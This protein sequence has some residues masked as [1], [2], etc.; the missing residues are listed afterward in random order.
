MPHFFIKKEQIINNFIE[1]QECDDFFHLTKSLRIKLGGCVKFIDEDKNVY[2][3]QIED[4]TKKSLKAKIISKKNSNRLLKTDLCLIQGVLALDSQ[5]LLIANATQA[6]IKEL[7]PIICDNSTVSIKNAKDK[8]D[9]WQKIAY[10]NFKQCE[11]ADFLK[12]HPVSTLRETLGEFKKNNVL[13]FV[14]KEDNTTFDKAISD[15]DK[16]EKI[17]VVIGPEGGFSDREFEYFKTY[18][19]LSLGKLIYKAP[20]A[21]VAAISNV[22]S[23]VEK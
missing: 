4:I 6:G 3:S 11:R 21:V 22:V 18:K 14:E 23:R 9:K 5:N 20:N 8:V 16:Q 15:I 19:K 17:A 7:F 2:L 10:E 1:L 13:I 12:I